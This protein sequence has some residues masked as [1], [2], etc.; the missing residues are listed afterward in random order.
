MRC[1]SWEVPVIVG[2]GVGFVELDSS[3]GQLV[4]NRKQ[5]DPTESAAALFGAKLRKLRDKAGLSQSQLADAIGYSND[6][7]S[8]VE[9]AA[10]A[11]SFQL[12]ERLDA[13]F[14]TDDQFQELQPLA[15]K[16]GIP[17]FFRPYASLE[18]T[19]NAIRVYESIAVTGLF[20]TEDYA[21]AIL[22][23]GQRTNVLD[24]AVSTRM[25]RQEILQQENPPWIV[26]LMQEATIRKIV[27]DNEIT[28]AQLARLLDLGK[29]PN[30]SIRIVPAEAQV[31]PSSGFTLFGCEGEPEIGFVE[32]AGGTGRVIEL[33]SHVEQLRQL[34]DLI[35]SVA[36][37]EM[38][39]EAL[40]REVM[41]GL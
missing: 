38:A 32:G 21:R 41:E 6:T 1:T 9:T 12:A 27:G 23:P 26:V 34:W 19:A 7:I 17:S 8:K 14:G 37:T 10:Q 3:G 29:E 20:E 39:S 25:A 11:P 13:H 30:I 15:A 22:R 33:S 4:V 40:I 16:E 18:S 24:R 5:L 35:S 2:S 28:K 36:M 31:F